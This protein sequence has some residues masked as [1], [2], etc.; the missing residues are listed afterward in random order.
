MLRIEILKDYSVEKLIEYISS[1]NVSVAFLL[2][3]V[4]GTNLDDEEKKNLL[5]NIV[6]AQNRIAEPL[7]IALKI[8]YF[9]F[10]FGIT[11]VF[12]EDMDDYIKDFKKYGY[13][14]KL[15]QYFWFSFSGF[16]FYLTIP[17]IVYLILKNF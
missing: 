4:E 12:N 2:E 9:F 14:K 11:S 7:N 13:K 1:N 3:K 8:L 15:K 16:I 5:K 17:V 10:P 6:L